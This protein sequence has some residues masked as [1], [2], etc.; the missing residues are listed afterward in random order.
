MWSIKGTVQQKKE[1]CV[2]NLYV[3]PHVYDLLSS[4]EHT[5]KYFEDIFYQAVK[6]SGVQNNI[7]QRVG[8]E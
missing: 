2:I 8:G 7:G 3:V 6:V 5:K 4:V 1:N